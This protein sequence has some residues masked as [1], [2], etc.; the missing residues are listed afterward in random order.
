MDP[1]RWLKNL[2]AD[3]EDLLDVYVK[4]VRNVSE[5]GVQAWHCS[6]TQGETRDIERVQKSALHIVLGNKYISYKHALEFVKLETLEQRR[7]KLSLKFA[8]K[9][10]KHKKF[11]H[12]FKMNSIDV[13]TR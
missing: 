2:E 10:E 13:N 5:L 3:E 1:S 6:R 11:R 8:L 7:V 9:A 12:W 4:Q